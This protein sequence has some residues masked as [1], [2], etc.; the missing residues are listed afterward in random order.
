MKI[1]NPNIEIQNKLLISIL[2]VA[3]L[4]SAGPA[5]AICEGPIVPCGGKICIEKDTEG[6]CIQYQDQPS[7]QFCHIFVLIT[8][9]I[10]YILT[11]LTPIIGGLMIII[12][13]LYL[14]TAGASPETFGKAK[15][16]LT[17]AVIGI[18]IILLAWVFLNTLLDYME[19]KE[20]TGLTEG[21]WD[22][23]GKCPVR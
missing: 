4:F 3:F 17:A 16:V 23:T 7:C 10:N 8:N 19:I 14:L 15:S 9:I 2:I 13:G 5:L 21:W 11:C 22:F 1:R 6:K 18:A 12:G 20:W